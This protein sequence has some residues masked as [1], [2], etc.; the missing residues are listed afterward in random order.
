MRI[1]QVIVANPA[2]IGIGIGG[3]TAIVVRNGMKAEVIGSGLIIVIDG[4]NI[5]KANVDDFLEKKPVSI[6]DLTVHIL[7]CGDLYEIPQRNPPTN[8]Y[9]C[10]LPANSILLI[11]Q[12]IAVCAVFNNL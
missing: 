10:I 6:C 2:T 11:K 8:K 12:W 9:D 7:S 1:A 4:C 5:G 3:N